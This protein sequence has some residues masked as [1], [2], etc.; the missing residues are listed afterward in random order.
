MALGDRLNRIMMEKGIKQ[1]Q[2]AKKA[3][4]SRLT[5]SAIQHGKSTPTHA[6]I[7]K[8][9]EA[10]GLSVSE[11]LGESHALGS[12]PSISQINENQL[13]ERITKL[14]QEIKVGFARIEAMLQMLK[15]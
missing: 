3:G 10:L 7:L 13:A 4:V 6:T 15:K 5:I 12:K 9:S 14:E 11:L 8:L 1:R 2:L